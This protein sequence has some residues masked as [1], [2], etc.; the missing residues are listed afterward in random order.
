MNETERGQDRELLALIDALGESPDAI[1]SMLDGGERTHRDALEILAMLP[2]SLEPVEPSA[3]FKRRLLAAIDKDKVV[4]PPFTNDGAG[5]TRKASR[6][7]RWGL[8]LAAALALALIGVGGYQE[9]RLQRQREVIADLRGQLEQAQTT[10]A[11][12]SHAANQLEESRARLAMITAA[13]TE[14]CALHPPAGS[15]APQARGTLVMNAGDG[16]WL[17]H[18][19]GLSPE[20]FGARYQLWFVTDG[21]PYLAATFTV[22]REDTPV[23]VRSAGMPTGMRGVMLTP[24]AAEEGAPP[25]LYGDERM[26]IL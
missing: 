22:D 4:A 8:P 11:T 5:R 7:W 16:Q 2:Y 10:S 26:R 25:L 18:V 14:F 6:P 21:E 1:T 23:E 24:E 17:L 20:Q 9:Q 12:L 13:D 15:A 3:H 19:K